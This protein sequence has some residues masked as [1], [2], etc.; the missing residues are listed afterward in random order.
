MADGV[1]SLSDFATDFIVLVFVGLA[2]KHADDSHPYGHGKYET[3][4]TLLIA[5]AL[6]IVAVG[7]GIG[8]V[9]TI[10]ECTPSATSASLWPYHPKNIFRTISTALTQKPIQVTRFIVD[11][12]ELSTLL[13]PDIVIF[14][15]YSF[16]F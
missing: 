4:A 1:H 10:I 8:G 15:L 12:I 5:V 13:V 6:L 2:Y 11:T 16:V 9:R 7:L 3:F 14:Q